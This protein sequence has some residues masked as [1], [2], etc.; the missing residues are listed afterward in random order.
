MD[1]VLADD[2][3]GAAEIAGVGF[4]YGLAAAVQLDPGSTPACDLAVLDSDSRSRSQADAVRLVG[5]VVDQ[6]NWV[7]KK[8][9][10]VLRGHVLAEIQPFLQSARYRR[11]LVVPFNPELGRTIKDGV[12]RIGGRPINQT[13][14]RDD[15]EYPALVS[16]VRTMLAAGTGGVRVCRVSESLPE[17][18]VVIGEGETPEELRGW[19]ERVDETTLP[20]GAAPFFAALLQSRGRA[21]ARRQCQEPAGKVL[22]VSGTTAR[23]VDWRCARKAGEVRIL[24]MPEA[25]FHTGS[26]E[27]LADWVK[28]VG[29]ALDE[30]GFAAASIGGTQMLDRSQSARLAGHLADLAASVLARHAVDQLWLE[31]GATA[32]AVIRKMGWMGLRVAGELGPGV[33]QLRPPIGSPLV[34]VKPG[35]YPL[36]R[37]DV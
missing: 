24:P 22:V 21:V 20:V 10:S 25:V 6:G 33:V 9:D 4:R 27:F 3:S 32:S 30:T 15:P 1:R 29:V 23:V 5:S 36:V 11:A 35:S 28:K 34:T 14:F 17:T 26:R 37:T 19:A 12:Y 2:F 8:I 16:D 13:P 18:G 31:G 7:F